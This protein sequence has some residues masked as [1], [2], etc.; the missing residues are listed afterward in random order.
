[1]ASAQ[2]FGLVHLSRADDARPLGGPDMG[3]MGLAAPFG[4]QPAP[5]CR[6][7]SRASRRHW[8]ARTALLPVT[9]KSS[10]PIAG[11]TGRSKTS[12]S[13][14][15]PPGRSRRPRRS[16]PGR[17]RASAIKPPVLVALDGVAHEHADGG[18]HRHRD[19]QAHEAE[20]RPEGRQRED[21]PDGMQPHRAS[22][23][24]GREDVALD[25]LARL[26][27]PPRRG[28]HQSPQNWNRR[29]PDRQG[30]AHQRAQIGDEGQ[31]P[32]NQPHDKAELQP[33]HHQRHG[34][35]RAEDQA[36]RALPRTKLTQACGR[37]AARGRGSSAHGR[38]ATGRRSVPPCGP[39]R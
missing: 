11:R 3:Q 4:S 32:R 39:S 14:I 19:Q 17:L 9:K 10:R 1:V 18:G 12:C 37:S 25:Q 21:Q 6:R 22:H 23:Q 13:A 26:E 38:A 20:Q 24:L 27:H 5:A 8:P 31:K 33:D 2:D 16:D 30:P 34:V 28:D 29:Q 15:R 35:E 36:D 7:A